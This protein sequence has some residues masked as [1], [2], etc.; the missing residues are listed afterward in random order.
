M[1]KR[2]FSV[3]AL[4]LTLFAGY[5]GLFSQ[6]TATN[7]V[8]GERAYMQNKLNEAI[9]AFEAALADDPK[10]EMIYLYLGISYMQT[11][12]VDSAVAIFR[13][14]QGLSTLKGYLFSA[15][16]GDCYSRLKKSN[17]ADEMYSQAL[18]QK[19]DY[20]PAVLSRANVRLSQ[21]RDEE[22]L[23][24]YQHYLN[25]SPDSPQRPSIEKVI[26]LLKGHKEDA[27][28]RAAA[29]A[30]EKAAEEERQKK[31]LDD[32]NQSLKQA[33]AETQGSSAGAE[34]AQGYD[35]EGT[36]AD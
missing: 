3:A 19:P 12:K 22:A 23:S 13:K 26:A 16:L 6:E 10:N 8:R 14:G 29:A 21:K 25:L 35:D 31:L 30:A 2:L 9:P 34:G 1:S 17:F 32:V 15:Y 18:E 20:A 5:G 27:E 33:A 24:D 7:L 11:G 28:R 4:A 36:L